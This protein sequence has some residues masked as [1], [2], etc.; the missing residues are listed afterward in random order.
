[1][2]A[3]TGYSDG[4]KHIFNPSVNKSLVII[5]VRSLVNDFVLGV[6]Q[7]LEALESD[8]E[9]RK[10]VENRLPQ[11]YSWIPMPKEEDS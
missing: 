4:G 8:A 5:G 6:S 10:R 11:I 9:L 3:E 2:A 7:F 1:M